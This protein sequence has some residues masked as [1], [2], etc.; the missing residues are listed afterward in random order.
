[1]EPNQIE[2]QPASSKLVPIVIVS[3]V[4]AA[5]VAGGGVYSYEKNQID[6]LNTQLSAI[7]S[8]PSPTP[9]STASPA[10]SASP[11][12]TS[13]PATTLSTAT[14]LSTPHVS[15]PANWLKYTDPSSKYSIYYPQGYVSKDESS[16]NSTGGPIFYPAGGTITAYNN[17]GLDG[18]YSV[19]EDI[20]KNESGQSGVQIQSNIT[21]TM[22]SNKVQVVV[23]H[24][25]TNAYDGTE[26]DICIF[27]STSSYVMQS[28]YSNKATLETMAATFEFSK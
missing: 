25:K 20:A 18:A 12:V 7:K 27:G 24:R 23:L 1:M 11:A 10:A 16:G 5:L 3:I 8:M 21:K 14:P 28:D 15:I 19:N 4:M 13:T 6:S 26:E 2:P 17:I 9:I 22:G